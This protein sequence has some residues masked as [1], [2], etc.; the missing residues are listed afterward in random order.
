[1]PTGG[2]PVRVRPNA[3]TD[4]NG[5]AVAYTDVDTDTDTDEN[6][7]VDPS[8]YQHAAAHADPLVMVP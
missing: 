6:P 1:M 3:H 8:A 5:R 4:R 7:N 2:L